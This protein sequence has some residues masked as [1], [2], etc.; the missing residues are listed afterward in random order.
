M[1]QEAG[2]RSHGRSSGP[3]AFSA[4]LGRPKDFGEAA[5]EPHPLVQLSS[6]EVQRASRACSEFASRQ[7]FSHEELRFNTITLQVRL[8]RSSRAAGA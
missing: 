5:N 1:L 8:R 2:E 4:Q 6:S 7:G 3:A